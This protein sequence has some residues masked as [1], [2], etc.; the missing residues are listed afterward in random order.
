MFKN[1]QDLFRI[2]DMPK[3]LDSSTSE[4]LEYFPQICLPEEYKFCLNVKYARMIKIKEINENMN[5]KCSTNQIEINSNC[6]KN[7]T[8]I[9]LGADDFYNS[10]ETITI[11]HTSNEIGLDFSEDV[12]LIYKC[13]SNLNCVNLL[14]SDITNFNEIVTILEDK[15]VSKI[16]LKTNK[17]S[18]IS[19]E[20]LASS[21][22]GCAVVY[23]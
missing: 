18:A 2:L 23:N 5:I 11:D 4:T 20:Y 1:K 12:N 15:K 7:L 9:T 8:D 13:F 14:I 17:D 22:T 21:K 16:S 3:T 6:I 19:G 10:I